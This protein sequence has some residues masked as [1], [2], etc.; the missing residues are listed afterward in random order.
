MGKIIGCMESRI[1]PRKLTRFWSSVERDAGEI[2][3]V[4]EEGL[5]FYLKNN[6]PLFANDHMIAII[7]DANL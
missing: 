4:K 7:N 5:Q 6:S 2:I 1:R 3:T